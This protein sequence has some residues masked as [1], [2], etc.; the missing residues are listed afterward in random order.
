MHELSICQALISQVETIA[1]DKLA[2]R[3]TAIHIGMG[4]L[5]GVE[6]QL[7]KNAYP[8]ASANTLADGAELF[9]TS[10]PVCIRCT[11]CEKDSEVKPNRLVCSHCG[12]WRTKLTSGDELLLMRVELDKMEKRQSADCA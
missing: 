1:R 4:P 7:L 6:E 5:S 2:S 9:I 12:D 10:I 3:V 11:K 8:M